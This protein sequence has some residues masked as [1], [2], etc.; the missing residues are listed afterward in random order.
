MSPVVASAVAKDVKQDIVKLDEQLHAM[1]ESIRKTN[2]AI[3]G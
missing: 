3:E 2:E 1:E